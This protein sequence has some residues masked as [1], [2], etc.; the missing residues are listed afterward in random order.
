MTKHV[1]SAFV[2]LMWTSI[3]CAQLAVATRTPQ[4]LKAREIF[5]RVIAFKTSV[6][7]GQVPAMAAYLAGELR[8]AGIPESEADR[9]SFG[10]RVRCSARIRTRCRALD[11]CLMR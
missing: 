9:K 5:Q 7:L 2:A 8:A 6:G 11:C 10:H 3:C 1:L 4:E